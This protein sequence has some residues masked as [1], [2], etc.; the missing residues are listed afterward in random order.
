MP[1]HFRDYKGVS[2]KRAIALLI[3]REPRN[4][5]EMRR[6]ALKQGGGIAETDDIED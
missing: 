5:A 2:W 3:Q 6:R 1:N 4:E